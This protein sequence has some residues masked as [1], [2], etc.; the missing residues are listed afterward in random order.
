[1]K[2]CDCTM[3]TVLRIE[4][5][6]FF[7][8]ANDHAPPHIHVIK[9]DDYAKID[10]ISGNVLENDMSPSDLKKARELCRQNKRL[11]KEAWDE[12]FKNC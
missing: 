1:M 4:G 11:L 2:Q 10:F 9:G 3:P 12:W 6:Q 5:F 8:F 7:F